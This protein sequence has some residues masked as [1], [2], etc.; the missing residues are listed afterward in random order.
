MT[1]TLVLLQ[2]LA[3]V[4]SRIILHQMSHVIYGMLI[5]SARMTMLKILR[6][7]EAARQLSAKETSGQLVSG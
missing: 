2:S 7:T 1:E 6:W 4:V 5:G 3:P